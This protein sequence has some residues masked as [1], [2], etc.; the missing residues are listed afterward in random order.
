MSD[1]D[2]RNWFDD[3]ETIVA[4][5]LNFKA[6]LAI[7]E[8]AYASLRVKNAVFQAWEVAG[9][10]STAAMVA[11]SSLIAS[12]FFAPTGFLAALGFGTA[13]T[14]VGWIIAASVV[15]GGA[16][17]GVTR[18][19]K[20]TSSNRVMVIPKFI[21]TPLD[22]LA[23]G[24]FDLLAPLALKI[25]QSDAVI[26]DNERGEIKAYFVREWGYHPD[27]VSEGLAYTE[28]KLDS[29]SV[30]ELAQALAQFTRS[31]PDCNFTQMSAE[32]IG[33]L[34]KIGPPRDQMNLA[35][36]QAQS[37][38][39]VIFK[40]AKRSSL[41]QKMKRGLVLCRDKTG[42]LFSRKRPGDDKP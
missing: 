42:R 3:I 18:Y 33:F 30:E 36:I 37:R 15:T 23:L 39:E 20:K 25:A 1:Q 32:I 16:W 41:R 2:T 38:I 26:E 13:V 35:E 21:N 10:A 28:A 22:V 14:P 7:G 19:L 12:T 9:V 4:E 11:K 8:D 40:A 5:P 31:N 17:V 27:F 6:K 34:R 24:L 29:F